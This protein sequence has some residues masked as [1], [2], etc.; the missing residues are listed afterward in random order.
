MQPTPKITEQ[1][2]E[3]VV[4]RDFPP[5]EVDGVLNLIDRADIREKNRSVMACLKLSKGKLARF[6]DELGVA[7]SDWRDVLSPAEYPNYSKR[8]WKRTEAMTEEE[9]QEIY[10]KDWKQYQDWLNQ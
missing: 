7:Q 9:R 3:R 6:K 5:D 10:D 2:I 8:S 1:D 4:R